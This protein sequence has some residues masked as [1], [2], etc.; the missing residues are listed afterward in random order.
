MR[1]PTDTWRQTGKMSASANTLSYSICI[2]GL[3]WGVSR[4]FD[5]ATVELSHGS[6]LGSTSCHLPDF[7]AILIEEPD[8]RTLEPRGNDLVPSPEF[9]SGRE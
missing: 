3:T 7:N 6:L 8:V 4:G 2:A 9:L 1:S 5:I